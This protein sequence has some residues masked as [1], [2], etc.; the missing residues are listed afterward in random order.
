MKGYSTFRK[1]PLKR[2]EMNQR[3]LALQL[4]TKE[5]GIRVSVPHTNTSITCWIQIV[6]YIYDTKTVLM[7]KGIGIIRPHMPEMPP[8][9]LSMGKLK[10]STKN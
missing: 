3:F 5:R 8:L 9:T 7:S 1:P 10:Q 4:E 6:G 2:A